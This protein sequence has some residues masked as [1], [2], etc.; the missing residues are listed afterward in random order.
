MTPGWREIASVA[1]KAGLL[2]FI[3]GSG[4]AYLILSGRLPWGY[5][6]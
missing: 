6:E 5:A 4:V 2:L 3:L 1:F